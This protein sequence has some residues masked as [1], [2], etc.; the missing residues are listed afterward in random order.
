[1]KHSLILFIILLSFQ[2]FGQIPVVVKPADTT[3]CFGDSIAFVAVL[4][5]GFSAPVQYQWQKNLIDLPGSTDSLY[6]I[7]KVSATSQGT[8]RCIITVAG[9]KDTSNNAVLRMHPKIN[10]DTLYRYNPLACSGECKGQFKAL[11]SGG[12]PFS[13][14]S[15]YIFDWHGGH[16]Q[17]T[18]VFGLCK[19]KYK[20]TIT[21]S[22]ECSIDTS[23]YV[24]VLKSPKVD[25]DILPKDT[26]YLTNPNI[27]VIF[28]DTAQQYILNWTYDFGDSTKIQNFNPLSHTYATTGKFPIK[29]SF[30]DKNGCDTVITHDLTVKVVELSIPNIFTPNGDGFNDKFPVTIKDLPKTEDFMQAYLSN[31]FL[32]FD[33]WGK[34]V[35]SQNNYKSEDWDGGK[36]SDGTYFYILKCHGQYSDD[37]FRGSVTI[38]R[39][40]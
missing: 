2:T 26:V 15:P 29:L 5:Q 10:V 20:L 16:S 18:I 40:Q 8:Y 36:L 14:T 31:E 7:S 25:F 27:Q 32:V 35:F 28:P 4:P 38:L 37:V 13:G 1:M 19:G 11:V 39:G 21:D 30:T 3:L 23:Y 33:R 9:D 22:L 6:V 17:D 12:T 34:K 24:D